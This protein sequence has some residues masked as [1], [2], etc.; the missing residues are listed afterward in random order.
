MKRRNTW[1]LVAGLGALATLIGCAASTSSGGGGGTADVQINKD[2]AYDP[3]TNLDHWQYTITHTDGTSQVVTLR[4]AGDKV[5]DGKT[6]T[7]LQI[8]T[9]PTMV[10][11]P[12]ASYL[13]V[14]AQPQGTTVIVAGGEV[15]Y[16]ALGLPPGTPDMTLNMTPPLA[17]ETNLPVGVP[18]SIT[19]TGSI[20]LGDPKTAVPVLE[21]ATGIVTLVST[22][23]TVQTAMGPKT[24]AHY[25]GAVT[26][27]DQPASGDLW[28]VSGL[29][30]VQASGT[31]PGL[32][33]NVKDAILG[34]ISA[35]GTAMDGD[36]TVA[37][38]EGMLTTSSTKFKLDTY[39]IDGGIYADKNTH[40]NMLLELRW[41]D[42]E[43]AKTATPPPVT[44]EFGTT[45]GYFPSTQVD[46][47]ISVLHPDENGK[48]YHFWTSLVN[49][50]AKNEPGGPETTYHIYATFTGGADAVRASG[51]LNYHS[52]K[53]K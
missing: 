23:E 34:I 32:P 24:A 45:M 48:G 41:A 37:S 35:G 28:T 13:E 15:H 12:S 21:T 1:W 46:S 36:H 33:G 39:D 22:T 10:N 53:V 2:I 38:Q 11:D 44:T 50:A 3:P 14:W 16:N 42:P 6:Y 27:L 18:Q 19:G 51:Q 25:T 49:Q 31:W 26:I 4:S 30:V 52:L 20:L 17:L 47:P 43:K 40:A 29:G 8:G 5:I 9:V 7:R